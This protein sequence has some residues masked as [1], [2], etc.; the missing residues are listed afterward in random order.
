MVLL[1]CGGLFERESRAPA[2]GSKSWLVGWLV[3]WLFGC[4]FGCLV[5]WLVIWLFGWLKH[6]EDFTSKIQRRIKNWRSI[7]M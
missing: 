5:L 6:I 2:K 1:W 3:V 7:K 4:L